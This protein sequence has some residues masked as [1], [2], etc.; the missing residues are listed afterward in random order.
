MEHLLFNCR[1]RD[2]LNRDSLVDVVVIGNHKYHV[3]DIIE[4]IQVI[5]RLII[6]EWG[7]LQNI[8]TYNIMPRQEEISRTRTMINQF[9]N[10]II[11]CLDITVCNKLKDRYR[12][13][14]TEEFA[15]FYNVTNNNSDS[16]I[17]QYFHTFLEIHDHVLDILYKCGETEEPFKKHLEKIMRNIIVIGRNKFKRN[18]DTIFVCDCMKELL[19]A[20]NLLC[21]NIYGV[22][23]FWRLCNKL[24]QKEDASFSLEFLKNVTD[25]DS[26]KN[27]FG[28]EDKLCI[29]NASNYELL[30]N[31]LKDVLIN[32]EYD[33]LPNVLKTVYSL[34][35]KAWAKDATVETHQILWDYYSK[36]LNVSSKNYESYNAREFFDLAEKILSN[37]KDCDESFE[38]FIGMLVC[39]LRN[40]PLHW[41]KMKGR[42]YSQLGPN[43]IKEMNEIGFVHIMLLFICLS[44]VQY[45]E[46]QKKILT[47]MQFY[48]PDRYLTVVWNV[49][50]A[51][52][53]T[54]VKEGHD[55]G[56]TH[57]PCLQMLRQSVCSNQK[58]F[59][60]VKDFLVN[61]E[62]IL[63]LSKS[64]HLKQWLL[65]DF[66][67]E[68]Y[69]QSC[70][71]A[72]L[73]LGLDV[74]LTT[75]Q[76]V[77]TPDSWPYWEPTFKTHIYPMLMSLANLKNPPSIVGTIAGKIALL[78]PQMSKD[79]IEFFNSDSLTTVISL[80]FLR[81]VLNNNFLL[82]SHQEI[83]VIQSWFKI[84]LLTLESTDDL[85]A[86]VLRLDLLPKLLKTHLE[87]TD[88][89]V[90]GLIEYLGRELNLKTES[91]NIHKLC[92]MTFGHASNWLHH[93]LTE[94][95]NEALV[96]RIYTYMSLA[97][98]YC[99]TLLYQK[100]KSTCPAVR[101]LQTLYFPNSFLVGNKAP[102]PFILN[103]IKK[104]WGL[105]FEALATLNTDSD[106]FIDR[107]LKDMIVKYMPYFSTSD[108]PIISC[109]EKEKPCSS[110]I[111]EKM[112]L[113]YMKHPVKEADDN[114]LKVLRILS[115]II[116]S[117]TSF[118]LL[119]LITH[120][121][122]YGLFELVIFHNQRN[123]SLNVIKVLTSSQLYSHVSA[124]FKKNIVLVT[125]KHLAFNTVN[126]FQLMYALARFVSSDIKDVMESIRH[127]VK[128][129]ER[130]R[131]VGFDR[132]LRLQFEKLENIL[133]EG[134]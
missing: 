80:P 111:L 84:C 70:Y 23:E 79:I 12:R 67:L 54:Q 2:R 27:N 19:L 13:K 117:S 90:R 106:S 83:L 132:N 112:Y 41:G 98:H 10:S 104:S 20:T 86:N 42:I 120:K 16:P 134:V 6:S 121:I 72:D 30:H 26:M 51:F 88:D 65:F 133:K 58:H 96:F 56:E 93:F 18:R 94:P 109:L 55:I 95:E 114:I 49:Y 33:A 71:Y 75:V 53:L 9:F 122:V 29:V 127:Q 37:P 107:T 115:N 131:G 14:I 110:V 102:H 24:L 8:A 61:F 15:V 47:F 78:A 11:H 129:V 91:A 59:H 25:L 76:K 97:F 125:Q 124:E 36:R 32:A 31:K 60:L 103:A 7:V 39:H 100:S 99:G 130:K 4:E 50:T 119:Q 43:K 66:W 28:V 87:N 77:G 81:V 118:S 21:N 101:L 52:I 74:I 3:R 82:T 48:P 92:D 85:T 45:A 69:F 38:I 113:C 40:N 35:N 123:N 62:H 46:S 73:K 5:R 34:A 89:P 68:K 64:M 1:E 105:L 63:S 57:L 17:Y 108:S 44:S 128:E 126:Y 116:L 22:Q